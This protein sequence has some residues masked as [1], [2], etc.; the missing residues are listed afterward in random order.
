LAKN[1]NRELKAQSRAMLSLKERP[2]SARAR[3][4]AAVPLS[5]SFGHAGGPQLM[6]VKGAYPPPASPERKVWF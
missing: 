5:T 1:A 4:K 6:T 2:L 3:L